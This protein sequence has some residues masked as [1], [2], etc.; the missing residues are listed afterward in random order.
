MF[1]QNNKANEVQNR[2]AKASHEIGKIFESC[3]GLIRCHL[4]MLMFLENVGSIGS[5]N[6]REI[7]VQ[8]MDVG[9]IFLYD[10][11]EMRQPCHVCFAVS[12]V[13]CWSVPL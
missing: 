7:N 11:C 9:Y 12:V 10:S 8:L 13:D 3:M 6:R 5:V 4:P 2:T 1:C